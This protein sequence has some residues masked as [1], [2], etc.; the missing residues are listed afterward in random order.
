M[1]MNVELAW[2][3]VGKVELLATDAPGMSHWRK[4]LFVAT[5]HLAADPIEYFVLPRG[6][7]LLMGS[8]LEL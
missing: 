3:D 6:R 4:R 7:T 2:L 8:H 1:I 5:A